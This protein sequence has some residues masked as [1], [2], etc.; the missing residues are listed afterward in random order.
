MGGWIEGCWGS[1]GW[2]G[3]RVVR[4]GGVQ[5]VGRGG[6]GPGGGW[7]GGGGGPGWVGRG[8]S[9]GRGPGV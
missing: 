9:D 6:G 4:G 3:P 7:V 8:I 2:W 1:R 5:G